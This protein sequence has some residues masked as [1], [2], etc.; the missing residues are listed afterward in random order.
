M[1]DTLM[2]V[3]LYLQG[4]GKMNWKKNFI[5]YV[6][7]N[8]YLIVIFSMQCM[9]VRQLCNSALDYIFLMSN[10]VKNMIREIVAVPSRRPLSQG[11]LKM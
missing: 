11:H 1:P 8:M 10:F 4:Q 5:R 2:T 6:A 7:H 9:Q 3:L